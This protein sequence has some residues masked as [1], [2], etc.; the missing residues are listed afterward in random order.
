LADPSITPW[1]IHPDKILRYLLNDK[2][3]GGASKNQF[4]RGAGYWP[5]SWHILEAA[6]SA[7]PALASL[8]KTMTTI[9]G[10]R[11]IF[12]CNMPMS[13][14]RR[15]YCI[16]SVWE[17]RSDGAFWLVTAYPQSG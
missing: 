14:N 13:P 8:H 12:R 17:Q 2:S 9:H 3:A 15:I 4:F 11:R 1:R 16:L 5:Q 10:E 6:L 7:H